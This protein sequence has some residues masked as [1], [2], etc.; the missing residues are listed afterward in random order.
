MSAKRI[1]ITF[2]I[3]ICIGFG[4]IGCNVDGSWGKRTTRNEI[5]SP[6]QQR[7]P[8]GQKNKNVDIKLVDGS[9]ENRSSV[10]FGKCLLFHSTKAFG[11]SSGGYDYTK[12]NHGSFPSR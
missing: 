11:F 2:T 5:A 10:E 7:N 8:F 9:Q 12:L 1:V 4:L 6:V 3:M